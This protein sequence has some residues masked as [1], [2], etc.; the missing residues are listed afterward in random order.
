M[1]GLERID[2]AL[3]LDLVQARRL[4]ARTMLVES[5]QFLNQSLRGFLVFGFVADHVGSPDFNLMI[6]RGLPSRRDWR[7]AD[8][9]SSSLPCRSRMPLKNPATCGT[10]SPQ[11][12]C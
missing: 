7:N 11:R 10:C 1:K 2:S 5:P 12:R 8:G 3:N 4:Q 9:N 6:P